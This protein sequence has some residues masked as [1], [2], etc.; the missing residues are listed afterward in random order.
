MLS[1]GFCFVLLI[2]AFVDPICVTNNLAANPF[3]PLL[4]AILEKI[5][6][7]TDVFICYLAY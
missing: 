3:L 1:K 5:S 4:K 2:S 7:K 6:L